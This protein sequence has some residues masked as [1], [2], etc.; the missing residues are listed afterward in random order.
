MLTVLGEDPETDGPPR[1]AQL[2]IT[3]GTGRVVARVVQ[4]RGRAAAGA[5][6]TAC[7]CDELRA[8]RLRS[9]QERGSTFF[10]SE[11]EG[12]TLAQESGSRS[13][14]KATPAFDVNHAHERRF[15]E[16]AACQAVENQERRKTP[17]WLAPD[18]Q[19]V[20]ANFSAA[21]VPADSARAQPMRR[22]TAESG[23][24]R[25]QT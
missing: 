2:E 7:L 24:L 15:P 5:A 6:P 21:V 17:M 18:G 25:I 13:A 23:R 16:R 12:S 20:G 19:R 1:C 14:I 10:A 22:I 8:Y 9:G 4:A 3:S 11:V